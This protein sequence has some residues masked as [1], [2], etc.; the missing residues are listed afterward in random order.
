MSVAESGRGSVPNCTG[1]R[2]SI[3]YAPGAIEVTTCPLSFV[4]VNVQFIAYITY[5]VGCPKAVVAPVRAPPAVTTTAASTAASAVKLSARRARAW[6]E[7][8]IGTLSILPRR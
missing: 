2:T 8:F 1:V 6:I 5:S 7:I 4:I 3:W